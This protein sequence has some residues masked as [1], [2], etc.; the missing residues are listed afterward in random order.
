MM[1]PGSEAACQLQS[2]CLQEAQKG[3]L[4][5]KVLASEFY[6]ESILHLLFGGAMDWKQESEKHGTI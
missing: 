1:R 4:P 3:G 6:S 2:A 5:F